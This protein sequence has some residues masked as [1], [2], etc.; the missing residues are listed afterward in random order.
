M[1]KRIP[2]PNYTQIPN[3]ILDNLPDFSAAELPVIL[4]ICRHTFGWHKDEARISLST[5]ERETGL[6]QQGVMN[7]L[8]GLI[9]RGL[10]LKIPSPQGSVFELLVGTDTE[11]EAPNG[12]GR[13]SQRGGEGVPNGVGSTNKERIKEN[14]TPMLPMGEGRDEEP[15]PPPM[16]NGTKQFIDA[17]FPAFESHFKLPYMLSKTMDPTAAKK[18]MALGVP[19]GKLI[20]TA[21]EAWKYP[22]KFYCA[23]SA[24]I[25]GFVNNFNHIVHELQGIQKAAQPK[26]YDANI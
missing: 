17:W 8:D 21:R 20:A 25:N 11:G 26:R 13:G 9:K 24:T 3:A 14:S 22:D 15:E 19:L 16:V 2:P 5:F 1:S 18:I 12:V 4:T 10:V 7:A 23:K 6:S